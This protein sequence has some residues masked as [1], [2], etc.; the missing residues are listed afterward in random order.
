[1]Y[2]GWPVCVTLP[3]NVAKNKQNQSPLKPIFTL[4]VLIRF[5]MGQEGGELFKDQSGKAN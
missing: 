2:S 4:Q 1:M 5:V 3:F